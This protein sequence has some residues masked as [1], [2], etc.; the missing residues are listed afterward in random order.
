LKNFKSLL[1]LLATLSLYFT[2]AIA[3]E[4]RPSAAAPEVDV[5]TVIN[6]RVTIGK[7]DLFY[8]EAGDPRAQTILLLHGFPTSS[9]MFR[10]L[11]PTLARKYHV[12]APDFPGFGLSKSPSRANYDYTFENLANVIDGFLDAKGIQ[13][14]SMYVMDYG[15][16]V[17]WRLALAH[18]KRVTSIVV[19]NGNAYDEGLLDFWAPFKTYWQDGSEASRQALRQFLTLEATNWQYTHGQPNQNLIS[20][21]AAIVDQYFLDQG[22]NKE[23]QLD[24]FYDYR[25]NVALYPKV[26]EY[27]RKNQPPTLIVWGRNDFIFPFQGAEAYRKDLPNLEVIYMDGGH[28]ILESHGPQ[29]ARRIMTFLDT[30][31]GTGK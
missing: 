17:G 14:F 2:P 29:M 15:A 5:V 18:P 23:I 24:L 3:A 30:K 4:V 7:V 9:V 21:D 31:K 12:L 6:Q 10:N 27:F 26:Q 20:P 25:N 11:I 1:V 19:Q 13:S 22:E 28:F 8:R 16:P